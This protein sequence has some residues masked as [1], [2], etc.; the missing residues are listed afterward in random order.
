MK[1]GVSVRQ[2]QA[3]LT[4]IASRLEKQYPNSNAKV[5]AVVTSLQESL[6][7][8]TR[9]SLLMLLGAV[10]LVLLIACANVANLL[11]SKAVARQKEMAIRSA[12]GGLPCASS[13]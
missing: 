3:E 7:G 2:A 10:G 8:N 1:P 13:P 9:A 12:L 4:V 11:L 6:V 5:G